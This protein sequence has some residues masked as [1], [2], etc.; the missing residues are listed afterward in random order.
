MSGIK[1]TDGEINKRVEVCFKNRYVKGMRQIDWVK[2]C[3][4]EY[5]DKSEKT[6][7]SYWIKSKDKYNDSWREKLSKQLDPAVNELINLLA[8]DDAKVR[9]RAV[10]QIMK[11]NGEDEIKVAIS[12]QMDIKLAWGET[13]EKESTDI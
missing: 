7:I 12:G 3:H 6:Y 9:Q 4:S 10:D 8:N 2:Y 5:G 13:I 11:F 1:M